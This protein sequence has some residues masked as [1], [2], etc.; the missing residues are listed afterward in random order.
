MTDTATPLWQSLRFEMTPR[1]LEVRRVERVTP[2]MVRLTL[3]GE[4][5]AGFDTGSPRDHLKLL[6]PSNGVAPA[7]PVAGPD[8]LRYPAGQPRPLMRDYTPRRFDAVAG[9]RDVDVVL[10]GDGLVSSLAVK[11]K[12]GELVGVL[13]P[14]GSKV[15]N[16]GFDWYLL[17]GDES[18]LPTIGRWLEE[19]PAGARAIAVVEV[20]GRAEEQEIASA[21]ETTI[22]WVHRNGAAPGTAE[23]LLPALREL[24][25]PVGEGIAWIGG[26]ATTIRPLRR[27]LVEERGID[28]ER[29]LFTGHWRRGVV[30]WDHHEP[31]EV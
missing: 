2:R 11:A 27:L 7:M 23:V 1:L 20:E 12:P 22:V 21:A 6:T 24:T 29:V 15:L 28:R 25:L 18:A 31:I 17:I 10:H 4:Q 19:L 8:G 16:R 13:G 9:E 30:D 26:E 3:G 5:L 14:R